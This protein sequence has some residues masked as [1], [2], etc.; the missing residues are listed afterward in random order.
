MPAENIEQ[1]IDR[2]EEFGRRETAPRLMPHRLVPRRTTASGDGFGLRI[3]CQQS[4]YPIA[5]LDP[6]TGFRTQC[7]IAAQAVQHLRPH[8]FAGV[9]ATAVTGIID[10]PAF[11][12]I[13]YLVRFGQCRMVFPKHEHRIGIFGVFG[14]QRQRNAPL[15]SQRRRRSGR[16]ERDAADIVRHLFAALFQSFAHTLLQG[17]D[18]VQRM[19]TVP[20]QGGIAVKSLLPAGIRR[21]RRCDF[22][23]VGRADNQTAHR[24]AAEI[25]SYYILGLSLHI[26]SQHKKIAKNL[27]V[28]TF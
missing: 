22:R 16:V 24:I 6:R 17:F 8:P 21:H 5:V 15:V 9:G 3:S 26:T 11:R 4:T 20:I 28:K 10:L 25:D 23:P 13:V 7:G 18:I 19:L 14:Q 12:Q 1:R 2:R 27:F